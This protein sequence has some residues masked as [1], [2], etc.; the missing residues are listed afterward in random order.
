MPVDFE[1]RTLEKFDQMFEM[2][3]NLCDR[4][5]K[6][7]LM[8][9]HHFKELEQRKEENNKKFYMIIGVMGVIFATV[10]ILQGLL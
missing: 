3:R 2:I 7:E 4:Q 1:E 8:L 6:T 9:D 10:E 5:T